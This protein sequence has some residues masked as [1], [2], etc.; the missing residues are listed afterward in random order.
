MAKLNIANSPIKKQVNMNNLIFVLIAS[1]VFIRLISLGLYPLYDT[2]EAR[3]G[4]IAR[5]M[6]ETQ[7]WL[8]PAFNYQ[9]PFWGKPP[10][11]S[12]LSALSFQVLGVSEFSA[13]LPHFIMSV[14][15]VF[16]LYRFARRFYSAAI[17]HI[18][19]LILISC[20]GF[21]IA[22]GMVM[23]DAVLTF[24]ITLAMT[25]FWQHFNDS[26]IGKVDDKA[27]DK[28]RKKN[29][30]QSSVKNGVVFFSALAIGMLVKGPIA[31]VLVGIA[32][33]SWSIING[34]FLKAIKSLPWLYGSLTFSLLAGPWYFL[35]EQATPG[36]LEYFLWGEHVQRFLQPGWQGDLYGTAHDEVKGTI[37]LFG[38]AMAFPWSFIALF[39][40][41]KRYCVVNK[42][43]TILLN[44]SNE[45]KGDG[46]LIGKEESE[47]NDSHNKKELGSYVIAW[48]F[49]PMLLFTFSG[50]ILPAYVMPALPAFALWLAPK[51]KTIYPVLITSILSLL[52]VVIAIIY[53]G[54]GLINK[55]S[56]VE[57]INKKVM[58]KKITLY[59]WQKRPFSAQFYSKGKAKLVTSNEQLKQLFTYSQ[60]F[61]FALPNPEIN[62]LSITLDNRCQ[63]NKASSKYSLYLCDSLQ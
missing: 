26:G 45:L 22:A 40:M 20:V 32:L 50:N 38:L 27:S 10:L 47:R 61:Y 58:T 56:Q 52:L 43:R 49:A 48:L 59:Y 13:R 7:N 12:W 34:C 24:S 46:G 29:T 54:T 2:T 9:V 62:K 31:I 57:L 11:H 14:A 16:I 37:W 5:I 17:A 42:K 33:V 4:E 36:F 44:I 55:S 60:A 30:E 21:I 8:T 19:A 51:F 28:N 15:T 41:F 3:Y 53:V 18:A 35:A 25:S 63:L 1:F 6:Y 23:T 39:F